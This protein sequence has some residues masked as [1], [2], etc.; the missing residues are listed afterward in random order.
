[1]FPYRLQLNKDYCFFPIRFLH[2]LATVGGGGGQPKP[3][4]IKD[5]LVMIDVLTIKV[6]LE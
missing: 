5:L 2:C 4:Q 3:L 1:M 6:L